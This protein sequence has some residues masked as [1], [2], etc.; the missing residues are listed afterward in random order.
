[1]LFDRDAFATWM[2]PD[3]DAA[4]QLMLPCDPGL[5]EAYPV[6][7]RVGNVRN[8]DAGLVEPVRVAPPAPPKPQQGSLF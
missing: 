2:G 4:G 6:D 3:K 1:M 5:V 7:R 8:D